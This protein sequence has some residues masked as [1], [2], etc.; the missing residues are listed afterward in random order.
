MT[1]HIAEDVLAHS[2]DEGEWD[3]APEKIEVR[4][5]GTQVISARLPEELAQRFL[6][7][8]ERRGIKPSQLAREAIEL[9]LEDD[10]RLEGVKYYLGFKTRLWGP[11]TASYETETPLVFKETGSWVHS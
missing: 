10:A 3:D 6:D 5:S 8:A 7:E 11:P 1:D 2:E 9:L 4:P